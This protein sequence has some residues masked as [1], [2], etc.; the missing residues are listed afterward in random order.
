MTWC[1]RMVITRK[2]SGGPR[3][4]VDYQALNKF[5]S[6][7]THH[8]MSPFHQ[9]T[10]F[11]ANMKKTVTDAWSGY[12]SVPIHE[13]D[14]HYTD[15]IHHAMGPIQVQTPASGVRRCRRWLYTRRYDEVVADIPHKT[16]C[17]DDVGMWAPTIE[18]AF[19]QT[20]KW[21]D[22]CG[23]HDITQNP[24]KFHFAKET[25]EFA[26]F[27]IT[28]TN[29]RPSDT[30]IR[31]IKD[32]LT[33]RNIT[34]VRS[35]FG[36]INQVSYC[37]SSSEELRP[38]RERLSPSTPF[39]WDDTMDAAFAHAKSEI[40]KTVADWVKIF[41]K[42]RKTCLSTDWCKYGIG[43]SLGQKQ[44]S[45]PSDEPWCCQT[46]WKLTFA[47]NRYTHNAEENYAPVEG[48]ALAVACAL[49]KARHFVLGCNDLIVATDHKPLPK[50]L[51]DR[52][53]EDIKN[54][55]LYN[56]E[57]KTLP[58][59]FRITHVSGKRHFTAD[60]LSRYASGDPNPNKMDLPDDAHAATYS[61]VPTKLRWNQERRRTNNEEDHSYEAAAQEEHL[62]LGAM[63][64]LSSI[65]SV[66]WDNIR[67]QT[68]S[69]PTTR[70]LHDTILMGFPE[71]SRSMPKLTRIYHQYR[72]DLS[73]VEGVI[74]YQ[75][76]IVIPPSLR[77]QVL[78]TLHAAHQGAT[79]MNARAKASVFWP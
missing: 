16:K 58:V 9:A 40:V 25:V 59:L 35:L 60:S 30:F 78:E 21:M 75:D 69:D 72:S 77:D 18:E 76:R 64:T 62:T 10:L 57:E 43:F 26:G 73:I 2:K 4:C 5:C 19:F 39:Y 7:E 12:H 61:P 41:D 44:C 34:D 27:E 46:G 55:R 51:G 23:R 28:T 66:T 20:C 17:I 63:T 14:R 71:D 79:S 42:R 1:S 31:A 52:K 11:P 65:E 15:H 53:M 68:T 13:E 67:E 3:R 47:S 29:I 24:E 22:I 74:L 6:R 36:L 45:C 56:L 49:D 32:F 8:T 37:Q 38:F 54:P 48:E 33:P 70:Q 50:V